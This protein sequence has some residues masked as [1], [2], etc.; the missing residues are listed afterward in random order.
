MQGSLT[1]EIERF[2]EPWPVLEGDAAGNVLFLIHA[3]TALEER[4]VTQWVEL[5]RPEFPVTYS[6]ALVS[7]PRDS[8]PEHEGLANILEGDGATIVVPVHVA[9]RL[10]KLKNPGWPSFCSVIHESLIDGN[11]R[12]FLR[13]GQR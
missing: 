4:L 7:G 10:P 8:I 2:G 13:T 12:V 6:S 5:S 3:S 9:W 1:P 11:K